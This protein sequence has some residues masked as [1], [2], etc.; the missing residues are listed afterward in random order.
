MCFEGW[1]EGACLQ[2][3]SR[4]L[5]NFHKPKT[6][7]GSTGGLDGARQAGESSSPACAGETPCI[8]WSRLRP[9]DYP[10]VCGGDSRMSATPILY[11]GP[12]PRVR[13]RRGGIICQKSST[14]TIPACAGE[15]SALVSTSSGSRDH[16]RV[17]GGD[18]LTMTSLHITTGPSPRVRG[19]RLRR[20]KWTSANGT[21]PA[22]AG[23]TG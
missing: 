6:N 16:P 15:T 4:L 22:C 17:C 10:R 2:R 7:P 1:Q 23:E 5:K 9:M 21:I 19:R 14:G 8:A 18:A 20:M 3:L 13:G 12:S 11:M